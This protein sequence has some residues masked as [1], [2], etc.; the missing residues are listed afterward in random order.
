MNPTGR[1]MVV[2]NQASKEANV[3]KVDRNTGMLAATTES[4]PVPTPDTVVFKAK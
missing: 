3:L 1:W 4:V 2:V